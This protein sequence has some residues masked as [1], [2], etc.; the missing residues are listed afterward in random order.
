M[1][2][3]TKVVVV[4]T[5]RCDHGAWLV[6]LDRGSIANRALAIKRL[7]TAFADEFKDELHF[8]YEAGPCG[9]VIWR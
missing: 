4:V 3:K 7:V 5:R 1:C 8:V 2:A 9:F 6:V